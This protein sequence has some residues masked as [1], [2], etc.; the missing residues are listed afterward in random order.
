VAVR[1]LK[2]AVDATDQAGQAE[3][4]DAAAIPRSC[5]NARKR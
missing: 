1:L 3:D 4:A 2:T 5:S